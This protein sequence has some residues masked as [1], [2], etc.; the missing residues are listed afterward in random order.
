MNYATNTTCNDCSSVKDKD[1]SRHPVFPALT[2]M[3]N[4]V[5]DCERLTS[6][7]ARSLSEIEN[8]C[9]ALEIFTKAGS[10]QVLRKWK[11]K[12]QK[13]LYEEYHVADAQT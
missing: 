5:G 11:L 1:C 12:I 13:H 6:R 8:L 10:A 7:K 3:F 9:E 2:N 4:V